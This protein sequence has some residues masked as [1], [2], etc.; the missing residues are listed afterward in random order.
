[1]AYCRMAIIFDCDWLIFYDLRLFN[2][3]SVV[4]LALYWSEAVRHVES[5]GLRTIKGTRNREQ[6]IR[7][8]T[9]QKSCIIEYTVSDRLKFLFSVFRS[10][11]FLLCGVPS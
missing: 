8:S 6:R 2:D 4:N 11:F 1:M 10:L 5:K 3:T 7:I 9:Y